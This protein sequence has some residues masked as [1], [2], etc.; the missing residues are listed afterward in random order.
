MTQ[1]TPART[2]VS[3]E[4]H[5]FLGPHTQVLFLYN[6]TDANQTVLLA[7][8]NIFFVVNSSHQF[9]VDM[10]AEQQVRAAD[11][12][13]KVPNMTHRAGTTLFI[14]LMSL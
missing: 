6:T 10:H 13:L 12:G 1:H 11:A 14:L 2:V 3:M 5:I 4:G 9:S 7:L 8:H